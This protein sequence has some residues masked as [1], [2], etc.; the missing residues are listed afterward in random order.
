MLLLFILLRYE[1]S[2]S[3]ENTF[4][5]IVDQYSRD[6]TF[7]LLVL[8]YGSAF[9]V[10]FSEEKQEDELVREIRFSSVNFVAA[11][12][13]FRIYFLPSFFML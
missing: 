10:A 13:W 7:L 5:P 3:H 9:L 2:T 12:L 6:V 4:L 8:A 11:V 1:R